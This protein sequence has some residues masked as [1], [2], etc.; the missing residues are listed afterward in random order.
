MAFGIEARVPFLDHRLVELA[1]MLPDRLKIA[2]GRRKVA[3]RR[4]TEDLLPPAILARTD[5]IAFATPEEAWLRSALPNWRRLGQSAASESLELLLPGT[6]SRSVSQWSQGALSMDV[7]WRILSL[8]LWAR[9]VLGGHRDLLGDPQSP[10]RE[11]GTSPQREV[12][13]HTD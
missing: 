4:A 12:A 1:L 10:R 11:G 6:V 8:E 5:K 9:I 7:F 2:D 3:L 13:G